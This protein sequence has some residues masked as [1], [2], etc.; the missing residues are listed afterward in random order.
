MKQR[1]LH[2]RRLV[3]WTI[4]ELPMLWTPVPIIMA[5]VLI[6]LFGASEPSIRITGMVL[7]ISGLVPI[8]IS[9]LEL[10]REF[11]LPS[12]IEAAKSALRNRPKFHP[13]PNSAIVAGGIGPV[14]AGIVLSQAVESAPG[15]PLD[16]QIE[17][18]RSTVKMLRTDFE[19][20]KRSTTDTIERHRRELIQELQRLDAQ[21]SRQDDK[22]K[23]VH[24]TGL[25]WSASGTIWIGVGVILSSMSIELHRCL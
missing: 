24:T 15:D 25:A 6:G 8:F 3:V 17:A 21:L 23:S 14:G 13:P 11:R 2:A 1:L 18:L 7:Q 16:K 22:L 10:R 9:I 4:N 12:V 5:F 19:Q 20:T